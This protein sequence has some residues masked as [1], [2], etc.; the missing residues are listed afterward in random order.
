MSKTI[1]LQP[2]HLFT[3]WVNDKTEMSLIKFGHPLFVE[4]YFLCIED[5]ENFNT[6]IDQSTRIPSS[7]P[8]SLKEE[9]QAWW[10]SRH[11]R[12][13]SRMSFFLTES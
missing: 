9:H 11:E 10:T 12:I 4:N 6:F 1:T 5:H 3:V 13:A 8:I 7:I 2:I